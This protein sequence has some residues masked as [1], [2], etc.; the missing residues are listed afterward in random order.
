MRWAIEKIAPAAEGTL[1]RSPDSESR[2][3][4]SRSNGGNALLRLEFSDRLDVAPTD[5]EPEEHDS[6]G[7][8]RQAH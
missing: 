3:E 5:A 4:L 1:V 6:R 7:D 8:T 2:R